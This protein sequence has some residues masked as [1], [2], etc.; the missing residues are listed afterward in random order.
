L[1][2]R[3]PSHSR[4]NGI[5]INHNPAYNLNMIIIWNPHSDGE[6]VQAGNQ[7]RRHI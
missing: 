3:Q 7:R 5:N 2:M 4:I 1:M 6:Y